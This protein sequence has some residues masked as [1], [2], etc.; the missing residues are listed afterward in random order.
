M[1]S[2]ERVIA[3]LERRKIDHVPLDLQCGG[4]NSAL[5]KLTL[6]FKAKDPEELLMK[7]NID[8]RY[9]FPS[10][11]GSTNCAPPNV[12]TE[13]T[14]EFGGTEYMKCSYEAEGGIAGTYSDNQGSRPL[15]NCTT[16]KELANFPWPKTEWFNFDV[17]KERCQQYRDYAVMLGGWA[18]ILSR[19]FELFGMETALTNLYRR[20][21]LIHEAIKRITDYYYELYD[22]ALSTAGEGIQ[23][24]GFGDDFATQQNLMISPEMWRAFCK[25]PLARLFSLGKKHNVY[26]FFHACGA[27]RKIIP[28]LIEIGLDILFPVQPLAKGMDHAELKAEFGDRLAFWG[29]VDVQRILPFGTPEDVRR[30]V[31]ERIKIL[32][33]GGGYILSSSHNMLK[34]FPLEN[35]LAMYDEAM[36][37]KRHIDF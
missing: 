14:T 9:V 16:I 23:I 36:K 12:K 21:S 18:P 13:M 5:E 32:G 7:M 25:Q 22:T 24:A 28:D 10:Y 26:V 15:K 29:G 35:I 31:R 37:T 11:V 27:I 17:L 19:I 1:N 8:V 30:Y 34:S 4:P 2:K 3:S 6:H 20:P 33:S